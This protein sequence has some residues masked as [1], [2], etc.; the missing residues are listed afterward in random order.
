M[1][2]Q[3]TDILS[4]HRIRNYKKSLRQ[5]SIK[6]ENI[7]TDLFDL[8]FQFNKIKFAKIRSA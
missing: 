1:S 6:G 8:Q 4:V 3:K 5:N 7:F 2:P